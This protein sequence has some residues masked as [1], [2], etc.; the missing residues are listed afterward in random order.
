MAKVGQR[1]SIAPEAL[2][3]AIAN[4]GAAYSFIGGAIMA[5][6]RTLK[7]NTQGKS[8]QR[9]AYPRAWESAL[10][11]SYSRRVKE[12]EE[13]LRRE[14]SIAEEARQRSREAT[15]DPQRNELQK[16]N[17]Q[18]EYFRNGL[19]V[20]KLEEQSLVLRLEAINQRLELAEMAVD[21]FEDA[22]DSFIESLENFQSGNSSSVGGSERVAELVE[23]ARTLQS[24][25]I[26]EIAKESLDTL[27][28]ATERLLGER[29]FL[30]L[31]DDLDGLGAEELLHL[32]GAEE[33]SDAS[34]GRQDNSDEKRAAGLKKVRTLQDLSKLD[35]SDHFE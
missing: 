29:D 34:R 31:L 25:A 11:L 23:Y 6:R 32:K 14:Q 13:S 35:L 26:Q 15:Q 3:L 22:W 9:K 2:G 5:R 17:A 1:Q 33:A 12:R 30:N 10:Y 21:R 28:K 19:R 4:S 8:R 18:V 16:A 27:T 20:A 24:E 7:V